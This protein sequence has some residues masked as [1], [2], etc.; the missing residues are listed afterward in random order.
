MATRTITWPIM[1]A[2]MLAPAIS[3]AWAQDTA[4]PTPPFSMKTEEPRTGSNIR[5]DTAWGAL[6]YDKAYADLTPGQQ[7]MLKGRYVQMAE[8]DEPPFPVDGLGALHRSIAKANELARGGLG[9]LELEVL[10]DAAGTATRVDVVQAH[11]A[12]VAQYAAQIAML[13]KYKPA[14][15]QGKPCAMGFPFAITF[16][17]R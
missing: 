12:K 15:C 10:V 13:T 17:R 3:T 9:K 8:G 14:L 1:L 5:R 16:V 2:A 7:R 4:Q 11:D 6:P